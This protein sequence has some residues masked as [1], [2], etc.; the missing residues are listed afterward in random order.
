MNDID[1]KIVD[2]ILILEFNTPGSKAN[3]LTIRLM[4][5]LDSIIDSI[6]SKPDLKALII[7]SKKK[8]IFIA[9]AD[10]QEL[11]ELDSF[12][13][14]KE[15]AQ[16]G[17]DIF[18]KIE[19]LDIVTLSLID[20]A[21]I[22]GGL[23]ISLACDHR[24]ASRNSRVKIG[25]PEIKLGIVPGW[26]GVVRLLRLIGLENA[27]NM[28]VSG[29]V[30]SAKRA[31][32]YG[33]IDRLVENTHD[34]E[35]D[36]DFIKDILKRKKGKRVSVPFFV[37]RKAR[38]KAEKLSK[39]FG[40]APLKALALIERIYKKD[41][42][43]AFKEETDEFA[44]LVIK[45]EAKNLM[46]NFFLIRAPESIDQG[47]KFTPVKK[48]G[49]IGSGAMGRGIAYSIIS[50]DLPVILNDRSYDILNSSIRSIRSLFDFF[51]EKG[52]YAKKEVGS[53]I[54]LI[55]SSIS[56]DDYKDIDIVIEAIPEDLDAKRHLF[57]ELEENIP[58]DAIIATNT[59]SFPILR[60]SEFTNDPK[61]VV[62]LHFFNPVHRMKLVEVIRSE[63]TS[64]ETLVKAIDFVRRLGKIPIVVKDVP[65]FLVNRILFR[66]LKEALAIFEKWGSIQTIDCAVKD[67]GFPMGPF[68][69]MDGIGI[70]IT[71]DVGKVLEASYG[72]RMNLPSILE[73]LKNDGI[74]GKKSGMGFY[75]HRGRALKENPSLSI[76]AKKV[77]KS[78]LPANDIMNKI[79]SSMADEAERC[80]EESVVNEEETIDKALILGM[81]FPGFRSGLLRY[82]RERS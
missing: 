6:P 30:I 22:G 68:E 24:I 47:I 44:S 41:I 21:C 55:K 79:I 64:D 69:L 76:L 3:I 28:L 50:N 77:K 13:K 2:D 70:D 75:L 60:L 57:K 42:L 81:G 35:T 72:G 63:K 8:D 71:Y 82:K 80:L 56:L 43:E 11:R 31:F 26:G 58:K 25:L 51:I 5:E 39:R 20:G 40:E 23:E 73:K 32:S 10:I 14:A 4:K 19:E 12:E 18:N 16:M 9:G 46:R 37:F 62:G 27:T 74:L 67:F 48:C 53:K 7:K 38:S 65:G 52:Y 33:I 36:I 34:L 45:E 17:N 15:M 61:R 66:Y 29:E 54:K 1:L 78:S 49:I 59:S